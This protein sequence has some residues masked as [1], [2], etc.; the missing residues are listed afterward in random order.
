MPRPGVI[1]RFRRVSS[2]PKIFYGWKIVAISALA[3]ALSGPGQTYGVSTFID[4]L[5][6]DKD[7]SRSLVSGMYSAGTLTAG[8]TMAFI[9]RLVDLK[10]YRLM[11]TAIALA[12]GGALFFMSTVNVPAVLFV[13]F[14]LIRM[15]GQGSLTMVPSA[16]I[17]QWFSRQRA[18]ALTILALGGALSAASL[19][20]LNIWIIGNWGWRAM[21]M[22][23][24]A[25][26]VMVLA[27]LAWRFTRNRPEDMGLLPDGVPTAG[28]GGGDRVGASSRTGED[29]DSWTVGEAIRTPAFWIILVCSLV[30][31]MV[32]TGAQF[33]HMSI[34][35]SRGITVTVAA[36]V[37][38][39]SAG[40]RIAALPLIGYICDRVEVKYALLAGLVLQALA[41]LSLLIVNSNATAM[42]VGVFQGLKLGVL[43]LTS[44]LVWPHYFGRRN[45]ASIRGVAATGMVIGSS[46]GPL[47]FGLAFDIFGGYTEI[48]WIMTA[49]TFAGALGVLKLRKPE[50]QKVIEDRAGGRASAAGAGDT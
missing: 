7:W 48:I 40:V 20:L 19:P 6:E 41:I 35:T 5:M 2:R 42:L 9:G 29:D 44:G 34:M 31:S 24:A 47:P 23:W 26:M 8:L 17:A 33:H 32:G 38:S 21:W 39:A 36:A 1:N 3:V 10:G 11:L 18:R 13:G 28:K 46:L 16:L 49:I 4:P 37:F 45:L 22:F 25:V 14:M 15:F 50:R 12:F 30:P 27:P 43:A